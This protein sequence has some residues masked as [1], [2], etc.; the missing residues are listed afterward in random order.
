MRGETVLLGFASDVL[1][2]KMEKPENLD[3]A[4]RALAQVFHRPLTVQCYVD[5]A[6][7]SAVPSGVEDDG[8]VGTALRDLG[9]ELVDMS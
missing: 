8:M 7:R 6:R 5:T 4:Q 3:V 1:K 2:D 9:G